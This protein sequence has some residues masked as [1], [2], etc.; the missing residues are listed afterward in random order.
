MNGFRKRQLGILLVSIPVIA[1]I[2]VLAGGAGAN[3]NPSV[4]SKRAQ[5]QAAVDE[6]NKMDRQLE[7]VGN[8]WEGAQVH[9]ANTRRT[10]SSTR[11]SLTLARKSLG[12]ARRAQAQR[13]IAAYMEQGDASNS[14]VAI[15]LQATSLQDMINRIEAAQRISDH[16]AE[17]VKQVKAFGDQVAVKEHKLE[18]LQRN[19]EKYLAQVTAEKNSLNQKIADRR[20][21]VRSV[22][23]EIASILVEQAR[24]RRAEAER[25]RA[26]VARATGFTPVDHGPVHIVPGSPVGSQ[27]VQY[28]MSKLGDP[29][30]WGAAGPDEFDCSGLVV[31][32]YA[33][34]GVNLP[35]YTGDLEHSG[36]EVSYD[37]L[38][39]G[40]LVFFYGGSHVG[41]YIGGGQFIQAPHTGTVVQVSTLSG[42]G[43]GMSYAVRIGV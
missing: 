10:L 28:A 1:G 13:L 15:L 18:T 21:Y 2:L 35:H 14:T 20:A 29:Y 37:Q 9:L 42:Y 25:A 40:D 33:Q 30:V 24:E 6:I 7:Q 32:A 26:T 3:P 12:V 31:W 39:P 16:D 34:V 23:K 4:D 8:A 27:A 38:E 22:K 19:Q 41:M 36:P 5:A 11:D 43:G 17:V